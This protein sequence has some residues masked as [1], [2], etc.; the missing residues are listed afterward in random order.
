MDANWT[1]SQ[2]YKFFKRKDLGERHKAEGFNFM[3]LLFGAVAR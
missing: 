1:C 2:S 3:V